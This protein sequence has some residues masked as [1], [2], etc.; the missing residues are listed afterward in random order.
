[1][2]ISD[3]LR[4]SPRKPAPNATEKVVPAP[5][6]ERRGSDRRRVQGPAQLWWVSGSGEVVRADGEF[7]DAGGEG[8][9]AKMNKPVPV[10]KTAWFAFDSEQPWPSII[11]HSEASDN[12]FRLGATIEHLAA[13]PPDSGSVG[14][15]WFNS[16]GVLQCGGANVR[17]GKEGRL[18]LNSESAVPERA[19]VLIKGGEVCC[20]AFTHRCDARGDRHFI[21]VEVQT[22]AAPKY[23]GRAA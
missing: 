5:D 8:V 14:L 10:G 12:G 16:D 15:E 1:M 22:E 6:E 20:L 21:E 18:E 7:T 3:L 9:G 23:C 4:W 17:S 13:T 11:R 2:K 19:I